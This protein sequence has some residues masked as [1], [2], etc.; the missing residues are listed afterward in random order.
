MEITVPRA[1]LTTEA[2]MTMLRGA[3]DHAAEL[4]KAVYVAVM[5][6]SA[7]LVG[8]VGSDV[9]PRICAD[10][11][12][13]KAYTA[14]SMRMPTAAFKAMLE[15]VPDEREIFLGHE[16]HIA[17]VGGLPVVID[18]MVVGGVGVSGGGQAEDGACARAALVALGLEPD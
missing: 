5:D 12:Q 3:L 6:S 14:V 1:T 7:R 4:E 9:A 18:G 13:Q 11:A 15:K 16:G 8:F 2:V 17:A 10:V